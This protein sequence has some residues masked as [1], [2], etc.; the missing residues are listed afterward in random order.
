MGGQG[1]LNAKVSHG[2]CHQ[3]CPISSMWAQKS[4]YPSL[5]LFPG[6]P[7]TPSIRAP[8]PEKTWK[9]LKNKQVFQSF[10][11][12]K[13][14]LEINQQKIWKMWKF[15]ILGSENAKMEP[16]CS[17]NAVW[18]EVPK[19]SCFWN[20]FFDKIIN[21]ENAKAWL[22][23]HERCFVSFWANCLFP[24]EN[25]LTKSQK[26]A[27]IMKKTHHKSSLYW[28]SFFSSLWL[29]WEGFGTQK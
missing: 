12:S 24:H 11:P 3:F 6:A 5:N 17:L 14:C 10:W 19:K 15:K 9:D 25:A 26:H 2:T 16:K 22:C 4:L 8:G 29:I 27:Q 28:T 23:R 20:Q 18:I 13:K 1:V 7:L 21:F